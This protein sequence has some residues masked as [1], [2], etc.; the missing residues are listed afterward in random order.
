[1]PVRRSLL[2]LALVALFSGRVSLS[3]T[4]V[5][6]DGA[7]VIVQATSVPLTDVLSRF[8]QATG[9]KIV[10]DAAK[11]RQLV[12][13]EIDAASQAEALSQLLEGQGLSYALRL[14]PTGS[15]VEM[16]FLMAKGQAAAPPARSV[17]AAVERRE[18]YE[19]IEEPPAEPEITFP[20]PQEPG[21][22]VPDPLL[23]PAAISP[24]PGVGAPGPGPVPGLVTPFNAPWM[25]GAPSFPQAASYPAWR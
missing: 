4:D 15:A 25:P 8:S 23:D 16:L 11:P 9:T 2:F 24:P 21:E 3:G 13:V 10:Y 22:P 17:T 1:M 12:T 19:A 18:T 20:E 5:R 6:V 14:D 7:R